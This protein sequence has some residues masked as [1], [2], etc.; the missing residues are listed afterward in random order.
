M[1]SYTTTGT[2]LGGVGATFTCQ[3]EGD[4]DGDNDPSTFT[5]KGA[6]VEDDKK[7]KTAVTAPNMEESNPDE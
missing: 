3:A 4:L 5:L 1:Y 2:D 7:V 6:V